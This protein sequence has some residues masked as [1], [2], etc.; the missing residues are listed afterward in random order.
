[1]WPMQEEGSILLDNL[2]KAA[3]GLT[4]TV[5]KAGMEEPLPIQKQLMYKLRND[6]SHRM[7][8][9]K[10]KRTYKATPTEGSVLTLSDFK[11]RKLSSNSNTVDELHSGEGDTSSNFEPVSTSDFYSNIEEDSEEFYP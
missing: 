7:K 1:M 6:N 2:E 5:N 3:P 9:L 11:K 8:R 10:S 4:R